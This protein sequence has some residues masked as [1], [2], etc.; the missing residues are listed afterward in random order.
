L[1]A[2]FATPYDAVVADKIACVLCGGELSSAQFVDE[3]YL[4]DLER[5]MFIE[6]AKD[7]R[8]HARVR[9]MLETG[10]PLRN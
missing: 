7:E 5:K 1:Q 9:H 2:G 4:L 10:K 6:L 3:Q 8:T